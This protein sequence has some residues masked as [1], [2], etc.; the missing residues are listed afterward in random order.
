[1]PAG[2]HGTGPGH[3]EHE[4]AEVHRVQPVDVLVGI[5]LEQRGFV[6][7]LRRRRVLHEHRVDGR[8]RR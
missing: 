3:T 6:V 2:V 7:D 1:M 8:D 4:P 5:D